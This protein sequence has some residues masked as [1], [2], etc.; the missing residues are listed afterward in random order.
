[1]LVHHA[2]VRARE[3]RRREA[4][5]NRDGAD[6]AL[7]KRRN[8]VA[9][10]GEILAKYGKF[11]LDLVRTMARSQFA[12]ELRLADIQPELD[13]AARFGALARR[14]TAAEIVFAS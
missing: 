13:A 8:C 2:D 9:E 10:S 3:S 12:D 4:F 1:M 11:D 14:V 7:G 5:S 6:R